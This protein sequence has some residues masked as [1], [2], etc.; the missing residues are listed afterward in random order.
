MLKLEHVFIEISGRY[1]VRDF[2]AGFPEKS[3]TCIIGPNGAGKSTL[4]RAISN[5]LSLTRGT[6][7]FDSVDLQTLSARERARRISYLPQ[8]MQYAPS[9]PV[10][11]FVELGGDPWD[12]EWEPAWK[13][14]HLEHCLHLCN[15]A[16]LKEREVAT[17]SG[18]ERQ[19]VYLAQVI[20]QNTPVILLDEPS[21]FLDLK[22]MVLIED[23]LARIRD[24]GR[25]ILMVTHDLHTVR[26]IGTQVI[27][28][29]DGGIFA[30][31][32]PQAVLNPS[33]I[34]ELFDLDSET[35]RERFPT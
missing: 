12:N 4:L 29:K 34:G 35:L 10:P 6:L 20:Y 26:R 32:R 27:A 24:D 14:Q 30:T 15:V 13:A 23:T 11:L 1:I 33:L 22:N 5:I 8:T 7:S 28:L 16:H 17:L 2:S 25:T 9:F 19:R 21:S 18:G 31:D 3:L